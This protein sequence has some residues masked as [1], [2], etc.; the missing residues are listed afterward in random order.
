MLLKRS[1]TRCTAKLV[2]APDCVS[3]RLISA[4]RRS[5]LITDGLPQGKVVRRVFSAERPPYKKPSFFKIFGVFFV[6]FQSNYFATFAT[7]WAFVWACHGG[8]TGHLPPDPHDLY[9]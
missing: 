6:W 3:A 9:N 8:F 2:S 1:L 7:L 5:I 4:A